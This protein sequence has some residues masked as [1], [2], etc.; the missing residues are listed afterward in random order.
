MERRIATPDLDLSS[1]IAGIAVLALIIWLG[2]FPSTLLSIITR[3]V[4]SL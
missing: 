2:L 1:R 4:S 3:I